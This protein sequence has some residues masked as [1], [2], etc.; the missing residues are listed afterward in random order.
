MPYPLF[1]LGLRGAARRELRQ[2]E[3]ALVSAQL[4]DPTELQD[5]MWSLREESGG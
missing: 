3:C 5:A 4:A 1:V 2:L